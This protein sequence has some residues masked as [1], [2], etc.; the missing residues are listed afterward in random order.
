MI[1]PLQ[2][3][4][5]QNGLTGLRPV[6]APGGPTGAADGFRPSQD[7]L[8]RA[9]QS[10]AA[11]L[12]GG[13]AG[14]QMDGILRT[15]AQQL[16]V[17][18]T[19]GAG[20]VPQL[21]EQ[22]MQDYQ[23]AKESGIVLSPQTEE[24]IQKALQMAGGQNPQAGQDGGGAAPIGAAGGNNGARQA[25]GAQPSNGTAHPQPA[26]GP[27]NSNATQPPAAPDPSASA[28]NE[29]R[30]VS[31]GDPDNCGATSVIKQMQ[32]QY[33]DQAMKFETLP[34]G[35]VRVTMRDGY[36]TEL[37]PQQIDQARRASDYRGH[38]PRAREQAARMNA[39]GSARYAQ[40][41]GVSYEE[42]LR[43]INGR[44]WPQNVARYF[45]VEAQ[46]VNPQSLDGNGFAI[47]TN[48]THAANVMRAPNGRYYQDDHGRV[49][50]DG[51]RP[52]PYDGNIT[53]N[54]QNTGPTGSAWILRDRNQRPGHSNQVSGVSW[55]EMRGLVGG[56]GGHR[57]SSTGGGSPRTGASTPSSTGSSGGGSG[58]AT[59]RRVKSSSGTPHRSGSRT[60]SSSK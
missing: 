50:R 54:G 19:S 43:H 46:Q 26:Q 30:G 24:L 13:I 47:V 33:G 31:Q 22:L 44:N 3:A 37:S 35:N 38:D 9:G 32:H 58:H 36:S 59:T 18:A 52:R 34:N 27:Q 51:R 1:A 56:G 10:N 17:A 49:P 11:N 23:R 60:S 25:G 28:E 42:G 41:H 57:P 39:A 48:G 12:A 21:S 6:G 53:S 8:D 20:N 29:F 16:M 15:Q 55:G 4:Q 40:E 5:P 14:A 45:G 2:T 7:L